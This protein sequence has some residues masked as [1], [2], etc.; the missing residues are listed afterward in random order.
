[1]LQVK[2]NPVVGIDLGTSFS[3]IAFHDG[4]YTTTFGD[5]YD[6]RLISSVVYF[7]P[8]NGQAFVGEEAE[9]KSDDCLSNLIIGNYQYLYKVQGYSMARFIVAA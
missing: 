2:E 8:N 4:T 3:S 9:R 1:M 6:S 5:P 7:D